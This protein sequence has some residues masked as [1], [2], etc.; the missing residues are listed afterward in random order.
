MIL[1]LT[2]HRLDGHAFIVYH[3]D[4]SVKYETY[5]ISGIRYNYENYHKK[6]LKYKF[7]LLK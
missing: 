3:Q 5:Y 1:S 6:I 7:N 4:G 2:L